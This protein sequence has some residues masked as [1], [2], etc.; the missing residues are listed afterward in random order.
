MINAEDGE[1]GQAEEDD[2]DKGENELSLENFRDLVQAQGNARRLS[3]L[4]QKICPDESVSFRKLGY[5]TDVMFTFLRNKPKSSL[6][7]TFALGKR[8]ASGNN[9]M[10][11]GQITSAFAAEFIDDEDEDASAEKHAQVQKMEQALAA[12]NPKL[13]YAEG[14]GDN[15]DMMVD[16]IYFFNGTAVGGI[17]LFKQW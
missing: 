6:A 4:W 9:R 8:S 14:Q 3:A 16:C 11:D 13:W 1:E 15:C 5:C 2:E 12:F 17:F 10:K 7:E